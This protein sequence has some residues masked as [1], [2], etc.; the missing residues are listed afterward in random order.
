MSFH[1]QPEVNGTLGRLI[2]EKRK[3][4]D[5]SI[6][7]AGEVIGISFSTV[8]RFEAG[9]VSSDVPLRSFLAVCGWLGLSDRRTMQVAQEVG[10]P[11]EADAS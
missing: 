1:R 3:A 7:E 11:E 10:G 5:L 4:D 2:R 6:R 8:S 9:L